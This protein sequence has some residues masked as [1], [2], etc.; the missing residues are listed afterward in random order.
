MKK[1]LKKNKLILMI[2]ALLLVGIVTVGVEIKKNM[3]TPYDGDIVSFKYYYGS[4]NPAYF[5]CDIITAKNKR[6]IMTL[7]EQTLPNKARTVKRVLL[8]KDM[9]ELKKIINDNNIYEW[10]GFDEQE[11]HVYDADGFTLEVY[12]SDGRLLQAKGYMHY[13]ENYD[14]GS[15]ALY[16]YLDKLAQKYS[17]GF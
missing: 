7:K 3:K 13:P 14:V 16:E 11:E 6:I 17:R 1:Y 2:L 5:N 8:K 4:Y 9:D 12:Y 15:K 10:D